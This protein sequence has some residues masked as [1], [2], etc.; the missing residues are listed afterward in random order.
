[1]EGMMPDTYGDD[2]SAKELEMLV[3]YLAGLK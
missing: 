3:D 1:M 2:L